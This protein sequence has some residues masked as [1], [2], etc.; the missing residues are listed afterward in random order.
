MAQRKD[1][2]VRTCLN[3]EEAVN[4]LDSFPA[5]IVVTDVMMPK[6]DGL[7]L[8]KAIKTRFPLTS[9]V[10]ISGLGTVNQAVEA[11]R[12]GAYDYL[13]KPFDIDVVL[14]LMDGLIAHRKLLIENLE[15][16]K[17]NRKQ[18]RFENI[19]GQ[20]RVMY[21]VFETIA[22]VAETSASV[23]ITGESGTGKERVAEAIHFRSLRKDKPFVKVNCAALTETLINSELFGYEKGAFTGAQSTKKGHFEMADQGTIFLDEI[24]DIPLKTQVSLL[25]ILDLKCFQRVGGTKTLTVDARLLCATHQDLSAAIVEKRFREDL[26]FRI[27]VV[28]IHLPP[29]RDR[30]SDIPLL[31]D[32]FIKSC[33]AKMQKD[34]SGLSDDALSYLLTYSW[35]G[36]V[37]ELSNAMERAVIFTKNK[38]L[39]P[40][41]LSES[42]RL[43]RKNNTF[44]LKLDS[45]SLAQAE[46]KLISKVLEDQNWNLKQTAEKLEIARGT[47]Y[48]KMEK[49]GI[50]KPE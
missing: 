4:I 27:N 46:M 7:S 3:G 41:D 6:M 35:P 42:I 45:P 11:M 16:E 50:R 19:I 31:A 12:L 38:M 43:C 49:Y 28:T 32:Y 29:L 37:R 40:D 48:G 33:S 22:R 30:R 1:I 24:G 25:R 23:L 14:D 20:G 5:D 39:S 17:G 44:E 2:F 36:N 10:V 34:V 18:Y 21:E 47:L 26:F 13:M 8:L 9:V 15:Q